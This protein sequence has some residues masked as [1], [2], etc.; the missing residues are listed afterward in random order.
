MP[1]CSVEFAEVGHFL[2][3]ARALLSLLG[4]KPLPPNG[5]ESRGLNRKAAAETPHSKNT[6]APG[7]ATG[8]FVLLLQSE[9]QLE[10]ELCRNLQTARPATAE[11][12]IP[13]PDITGGS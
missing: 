9:N 12:G 11:E 10:R 5:P 6:K 2:W 4:G 8:A 7:W 1:K 3:S 13:D